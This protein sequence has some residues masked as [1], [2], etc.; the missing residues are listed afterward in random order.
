MGGGC[1]GQIKIMAS[2]GVASPTDKITSTQFS[3]EE[4][5]AAVEEAQAVGSYVMAHAYYPD[6][7]LRCVR[8]GVRSIE[9]GNH[10]DRAVLKEMVA[11]GA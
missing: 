4:I 1:L 7:V 9:H 10:L 11:P 3:E 8:N 5:R 2:G 6:A